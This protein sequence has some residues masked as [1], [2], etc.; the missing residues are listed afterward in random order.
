MRPALWIL[1]WSAIGMVAGIPVVML[2]EHFAGTPPELINVWLGA[3]TVWAG[4]GAGVMVYARWDW[5]GWL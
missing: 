3:A 2:V 5:P 1:M 4:W